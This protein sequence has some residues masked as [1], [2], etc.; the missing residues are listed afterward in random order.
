MAKKV[1]TTSAPL[2]DQASTGAAS[3]KK[4]GSASRPKHLKAQAVAVAA[5]VEGFVHSLNSTVTDSTATEHAVE[6]APHQLDPTPALVERAAAPEVTEPELHATSE[7]SHAEISALAYRFFLE[8]GGQNGSPADDWF[9]AEQ[10]L[11]S[12]R[13]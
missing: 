2:A 9:R 8:R 13:A 1:S 7:I 6:A 11:S 4:K 5:A 10:A 3:A 12:G